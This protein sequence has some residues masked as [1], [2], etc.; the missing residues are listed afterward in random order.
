MIRNPIVTFEN[1]NITTFVAKMK[2]YLFDQIYA[3][4]SLIF[5]LV[6]TAV[7]ILTTIPGLVVSLLV[8]V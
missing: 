7:F 8:Y 4:T 2:T 5:V 1:D 3:F 6:S